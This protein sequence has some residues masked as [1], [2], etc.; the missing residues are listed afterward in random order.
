MSVGIPL[1]NRLQSG[2]YPRDLRTYQL[3]LCVTHGRFASLESATRR[4]TSTFSV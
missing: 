1:R 2:C 4:R 3:A